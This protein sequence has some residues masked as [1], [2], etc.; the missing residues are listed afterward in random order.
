MRTVNI[1]EA[2]ENNTWFFIA[3]FWVAGFA[4]CLGIVK[5]VVPLSGFILV[6]KEQVIS[7]QEVQ[8]N[9]TANAVVQADYTKNTIIADQYVLI[10]A[11]ADQKLCG[12]DAGKFSNGTLLES[13]NGLL[14]AANSQVQ[15]V[16]DFAGFGMV[17]QPELFRTYVAHLK[18]I[19]QRGLVR[20]VVLSEARKKEVLAIQF[21]EYDRS[22]RSRQQVL[23]LCVTPHGQQAVRNLRHTN[24]QLNIYNLSKDEAIMVML[25]TEKVVSQ[26]LIDHGAEIFVFDYMI[27][28]HV[29]MNDE[30]GMIISLVD[31]HSISE[32]KGY[33]SRPDVFQEPF[34]SMLT[35]CTRYYPE[36]RLE[37][38]IGHI[39]DASHE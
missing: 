4:T 28:N 6:E 34:E 35:L 30:E 36:C 38:G 31:F 26:M 1:K 7:R 24:P 33:W 2:I 11:V 3:G 25:E 27:A 16:A 29:W 13:L 21:A 17:T 22:K 5:W 39:G 8:A 15:I 18:R 23:E 9:Y 10:G 14:Q 20:M 32:E 37:M 12:Q 19:A